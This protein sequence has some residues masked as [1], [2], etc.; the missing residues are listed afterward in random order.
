MAAVALCDHRFQ[1]IG[2]H[3]RSKPCGVGVDQKEKGLFGEYAR[4][5]LHKGIEVV[6]QLPDLAG[7]A[8]PIGGGVHDDGVIVKVA[9]EYIAKKID[10]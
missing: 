3:R 8:A 10:A 9:R 1:N 5:Q 6:L 4:H 2:E 7:R